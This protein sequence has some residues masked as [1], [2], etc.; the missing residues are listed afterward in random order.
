MPFQLL[1]ANQPTAH[2]AM[3][4]VLQV[5]AGYLLGIGTTKGGTTSL[6][7]YLQGWAN[8]PF[9]PHLLA[10]AN[11]ASKELYW[12]M[13]SDP[14]ASLQQYDALL[15]RLVH[16]PKEAQPVWEQ[17]FRQQS[18]KLYMCPA[19]ESKVMRGPQTAFKW[20]TDVNG[21]AVDK[22]KLT[23]L[24]RADVTPGGHCSK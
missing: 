23:P 1:S 13:H 14:S 2:V 9:H 24:Y 16:P 8:V 11:V 20:L 21:T 5:C 3:V 22:S 12:W 19:P 4:L 7:G 6:W 18:S 10:P 15:Q 17:L